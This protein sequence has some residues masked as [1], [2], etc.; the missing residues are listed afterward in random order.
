MFADKFKYKQ[1]KQTDRAGHRAQVNFGLQ[2][3]E[4]D[5]FGDVGDGLDRFKAVCMPGGQGKRHE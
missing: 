1:H 4:T 5:R 3:H 2:P